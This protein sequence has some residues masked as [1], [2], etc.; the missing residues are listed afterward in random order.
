MTKEITKARILQQ[1]QD[2]FQLR[3]FEATKF[4][5]DETVIPVFEISSEIQHPYTA[6]KAILITSADAF[7]FF[8]VPG[9]EKWILSNYNVIFLGTP[10]AIKASGVFVTRVNKS[11]ATATFYL[12]LKAGQETSYIVNLELP[13]V[14]EP[15]DTLSIYIDTYV[16]DQQMRL[17]I[18]HI[19]EEIR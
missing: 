18:D 4:L 10:G 2:K 1:L 6:S 16:S 12:D 19:T 9:T 7:A 13:V 8:T 5:F 3:E 14:L 15:G 17:I 11:A